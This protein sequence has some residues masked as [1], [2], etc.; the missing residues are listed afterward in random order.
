MFGFH[1]QAIYPAAALYEEELAV[2]REKLAQAD[3]VL[4]GAGAGLSTAAG[5]TYGGTRFQKYFADFAEVRHP[6]YVHRR[7][8]SVPES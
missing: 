3:A 5:L 2:L 8:L 1:V 6:R 7:V 4:V